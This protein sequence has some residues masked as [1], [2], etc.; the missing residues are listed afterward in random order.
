MDSVHICKHL[1]KHMLA[2]HLIIARLYLNVNLLIW[3]I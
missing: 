3:Q 2:A 1:E